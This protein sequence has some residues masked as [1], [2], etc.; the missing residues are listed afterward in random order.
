MEDRPVSEV[1]CRTRTGEILKVLERV[2]GKVDTVGHKVDHHLG[3]HEGT[4]RA[5]ATFRTRV[6]GKMKVAGVII[7]LLALLVSSAFGCIKLFGG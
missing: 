3:V 1:A 4:D 2:E 7:A 6:T 5:V